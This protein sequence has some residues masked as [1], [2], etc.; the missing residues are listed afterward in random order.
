V[1]RFSR[2][3]RPS[4][5]DDLGLL[6]AIEWVA[7]EMT[8]RGAASATVR[9]EGTPRRL[10]PEA[11]L[12]LFRIAQEA[13]RNVEKHAGPC[14]VSLEVN[15]RPEDVALTVTDNGRGFE[16]RETG[17]LAE[18]GKLGVL[19]MRERAQL[20]GA[21]F[22]IESRPGRGTSV[23]VRMPAGGEKHSDEPG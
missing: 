16:L 1:R 14:S 3:L 22:T 19:G 11:E 15:F 10:S 20:L 23:R 13:L 4:I 21:E 5:L 8:R 12:V 2:D 17:H 7:A 18:L 6:P 9:V